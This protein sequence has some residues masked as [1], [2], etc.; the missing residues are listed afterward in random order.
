MSEPVSSD[1]SVCHLVEADSQALE[2]VLTARAQG[3]DFVASTGDRRRVAAAAD[4]LRVLDQDAPA[5]PP[6]DLVARTLARVQDARQRERFA[7]QVEMLAAPRRTAGVSWR[8]L[9]SAAA[10]FL[11]ATSLLLPVLERNQTEAQRVIGAGNLS[12]A[13]IAL[14]QYA[15]DHDQKLPQLNARPGDTWL[16]VGQLFREDEPV[17]SNSAHLYVLIKNNYLTADQLA[18]P[19]NPHAPAPGALTD[20]HHDW[21]NP[22]QVSYSYQNQYGRY[23]IRI[24]EHADL[25]VLADRNPMF[26]VRD[27]KLYF[28]PAILQTA[29]SRN[30]KGMGQN[31]LVLDGRVH[32]LP[33]PE[34]DGDNIWTTKLHRHYDGD[35]APEEAGDAHLIP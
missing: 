11:I 34:I 35:E 14:Q 32:W 27:G 26:V 33:R 20:Q 8:Q 7:Q 19:G 10:I 2:A 24:E 30:H 13:G 25:P 28:N 4:L 3:S 21:Q 16:N 5:D 23:V 15:Q 17:T 22:R 9:V 6:D 1:K 18:C 29:P 12:S 31:V